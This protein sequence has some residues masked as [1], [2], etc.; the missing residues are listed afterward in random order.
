MYGSQISAKN[1]FGMVSTILLRF[2]R[3]YMESW[4]V[5]MRCWMCHLQ[6]MHLYKT[7]MDLSP[8]IMTNAG[9]VCQA[10]ACEAPRKGAGR[11]PTTLV[12][13]TGVGFHIGTWDMELILP[14]SMLK[15][16]YIQKP[17]VG[18][19]LAPPQARVHCRWWG[20]GIVPESGRQ[21]L[22]DKSLHGCLII[23]SIKDIDVICAHVH[24]HHSMNMF[25]LDCKTPGLINCV[26]PIMQIYYITQW[27]L[28]ILVSQ[29][30]LRS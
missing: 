20:Q 17:P 13:P 18:F 24:S 8:E 1:E 10:P 23:W 7:P 29:I 14:Q 6:G 11:L 9:A 12:E 4:I 2:W 26:K 5:F 16:A 21:K 25:A 15:M 22:V 19:D 27:G 30:Q 3:V 28:L